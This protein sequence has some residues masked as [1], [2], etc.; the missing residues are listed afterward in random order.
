MGSLRY[1]TRVQK[2]AESVSNVVPVQKGDRRGNYL[3]VVN[4]YNALDHNKEAELEEANTS[5]R[6]I[7]MFQRDANA[8]GDGK[9]SWRL[10]LQQYVRTGDN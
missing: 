2:I 3:V 4:G 5:Q 1:P 7:T 9:P 8:R 6:G 10:F